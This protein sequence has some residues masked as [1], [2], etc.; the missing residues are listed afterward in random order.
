MAGS[1]SFDASI[2]MTE[3]A[4]DYQ[5]R[6]RQLVVDHGPA[7]A[8]TLRYSGVSPEDLDDAVQEVFVIAHRRWA[9][10]DHW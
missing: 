5:Q 6:F 7:L 9:D 2:E 4:A 8:R 1:A 3:T 10:L